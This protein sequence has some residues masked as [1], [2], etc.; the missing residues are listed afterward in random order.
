MRRELRLLHR[1]LHHRDNQRV[2]QLVGRQLDRVGV[3]YRS[4]GSQLHCK[5][6]NFDWSINEEWWVIDRDRDS[7][8]ELVQRCGSWEDEAVLD[9]SSIRPECLARYMCEDI[10]PTER[11]NS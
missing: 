5:W 6:D 1:Q 9:G 8:G 3:R 2:V 7:R 4:R 11:F 10:L